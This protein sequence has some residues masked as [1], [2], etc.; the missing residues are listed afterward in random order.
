MAIGTN[1]TITPE[2]RGITLTP[3]TAKVKAGVDKLAVVVDWS[4]NGGVWGKLTLTD[5][6]EI[7]NPGFNVEA[8]PA[9]VTIG[10]GDGKVQNVEFLAPN[11]GPDD[12]YY[13]FV[14][15]LEPVTDPDKT[16]IIDPVIIIKPWY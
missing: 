8:S 16:W 10:A 3:K 5:F 15:V 6:K 9:S 13:S 11:F 7:D 2:P 12:K 14:I 1:L 4:T